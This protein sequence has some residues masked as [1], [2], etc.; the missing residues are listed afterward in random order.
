MNAF[1]LDGSKWTILIGIQLQE[2]C[3]MLFTALIITLAYGDL[4]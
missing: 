2:F 1:A 4:L 3:V